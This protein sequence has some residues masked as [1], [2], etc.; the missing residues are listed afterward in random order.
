[1]L[2]ESGMKGKEAEPLGFFLAMTSVIAM[3]MWVLLISSLMKVHQTAPLQPL[4]IVWYTSVLA[5]LFLLLAFALSSERRTMG[6]V[7][8]KRPGVSIAILLGSS[9][10]AAVYHLCAVGLVRLTSALGATV[11]ATTAIVLTVLLTAVS[12]DTYTASYDVAGFF[13][14]FAGLALYIYLRPAPR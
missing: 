3:A 13:L 8:A 2:S 1:M 11:A 9:A 6:P 5:A 12:S 10:A 7:L 4:S 14:F